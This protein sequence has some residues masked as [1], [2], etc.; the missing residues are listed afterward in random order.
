MNSYVLK[1]KCA[2]PKSVQYNVN[3][4]KEQQ[5]CMPIQKQISNISDNDN[6]EEVL[7]END[8]I[9]IPNIVTKENEEDVWEMLRKEPKDDTE[10][11]DKF[12]S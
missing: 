1:S 12:K 3:S 6:L 4:Y 7:F 10:R 9:E 5:D 8:E 11:E 2:M